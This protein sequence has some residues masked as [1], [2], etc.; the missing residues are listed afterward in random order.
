M[1]EVLVKYAGDVHR[2]KI[3]EMRLLIYPLRDLMKTYFEDQLQETGGSYRE[4]DA[5]L[6]GIEKIETDD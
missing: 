4:S 6:L 5:Y 1:F 2:I 3:S